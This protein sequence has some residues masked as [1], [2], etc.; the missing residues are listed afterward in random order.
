M[1]IAMYLAVRVL[2]LA[3]LAAAVFVALGTLVST[4]AVSQLTWRFV[5]L[6]FIAQGKRLRRT[7][8]PS[9]SSVPSGA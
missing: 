5:E 8:S 4:W 9:E 3:P 2:S 1:Q 7:N 6:P